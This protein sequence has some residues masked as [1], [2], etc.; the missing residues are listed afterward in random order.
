MQFCATAYGEMLLEDG[1]DL[2]VFLV[3]AVH[4]HA[5]PSTNVGEPNCA[6]VPPSRSPL[7]TWCTARAARKLARKAQEDR[8]LAL[9]GTLWRGLEEQ[10]CVLPSPSSC[11]TDGES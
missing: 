5:V 3:P 10:T 2:Y 8:K 1:L 6:P 4:A 11:H 7:L 9:V